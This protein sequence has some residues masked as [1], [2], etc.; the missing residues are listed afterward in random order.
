LYGAFVWARRALNSQKRL[1][2]ARADDHFDLPRRAFDFP[3]AVG[4]VP[5]YTDCSNGAQE[6]EVVRARVTTETLDRIVPQAGDQPPAVLPF[7]E[8]LSPFL[9]DTATKVQRVSAD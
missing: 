2:A 8:T 7:A 3:G 1:F 9:L 4:N 5:T 6:S